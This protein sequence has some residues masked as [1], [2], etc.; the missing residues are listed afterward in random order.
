M[1]KGELG[2]AGP[3]LQ[4]D[5]RTRPRQMMPEKPTPPATCTQDINAYV[6]V[7]STLRTASTPACASEISCRTLPAQNL[8]LFLT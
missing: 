4:V 3:F 7:T 6:Y 5:A 2:K 1:E 8:Q